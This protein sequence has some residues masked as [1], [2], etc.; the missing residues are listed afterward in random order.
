MGKIKELLY[1]EQNPEMFEEEAFDFYEPQW[2]GDIPPESE[3]LKAENEKLKAEIQ[4][5]KAENKDLVSHLGFEF[6]LSRMKL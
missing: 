2:A 4:Q 5:L 6:V 1:K 3:Q